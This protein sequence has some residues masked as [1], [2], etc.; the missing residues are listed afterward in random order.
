[1]SYSSNLF[2]L[3]NLNLLDKLEQSKTT[4][5][6]LSTA[7]FIFCSILF[8]LAD[9]CRNVFFRLHNSIIYLALFSTRDLCVGIHLIAQIFSTIET[10]TCFTTF[11]SIVYFSNF[12]RILRECYLIVLVKHFYGYIKLPASFMRS[13]RFN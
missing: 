13:G 8:L 7:F 1:M 9:I 2:Q 12:N 5:L 11:I 6:L 3:V 10:T 4:R